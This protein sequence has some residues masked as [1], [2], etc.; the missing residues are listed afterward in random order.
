MPPEQVVAGNAAVNASYSVTDVAGP[1]IGGLLVQAVTAPYAIVLDAIGFLVSGG[2]IA[3]L[4]ADDSGHRAARERWSVMVGDGFRFLVRSKPLLM[5]GISGGVANIFIQAYLTIF[6][7]FAVDTLGF[8]PVKIGALYAVG[9][10]GGVVGAA[11]AGRLG[12]RFSKVGAMV[13]GNVTVGAGMGLIAAAGAL[14]GG[15]VRPV[16]ATAGIWLYSMGLGV[17][18][19]H[20]MSA[21][22]QLCPPDK[23]GRITA[24]Y[25]LLSHGSLPLGALAGGYCARWAGQTTTIAL[26]GAGLVLW[27]GIAMATPFRRLDAEQAAAKVAPAA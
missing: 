11:F 3:T 4:K 2:L 13:G 26:A 1:G 6:V 24:G 14:D 21:R 19:V 8:S 5:L 27:M 9:A 23:L 15:V 22:Q 25:R 10:V 18:N 17:Y 7:L 12:E 20:S 16:C